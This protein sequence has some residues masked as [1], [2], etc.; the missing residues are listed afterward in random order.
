MR[1]IP[2]V[3][4]GE[5]TAYDTINME[6]SEY[7]DLDLTGLEKQTVMTKLEENQNLKNA[8]H[9]WQDWGGYYSEVFGFI[10]PEL[11]VY[12]VSRI[13]KMG[14]IKF[15]IFEMEDDGGIFSDEDGDALA[16]DMDVDSTDF[17][18]NHIYSYELGVVTVGEGYYSPAN[19][20]CGEAHPTVATHGLSF[21]QMI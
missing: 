21:G 9:I 10:I 15:D 3:Y 6:S 7:L 14:V 13:Q 19:S 8:L 20:D 1:V 11:N 16:E 2:I 17:D 12:Y 4:P 5:V 18:F